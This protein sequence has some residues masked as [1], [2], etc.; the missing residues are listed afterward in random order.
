LF[1][2]P[3]S[4]III[5]HLQVFKLFAHTPRKKGKMRKL[6]NRREKETTLNRKK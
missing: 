5:Y 3:F 2:H 1:T 4:P 6:R